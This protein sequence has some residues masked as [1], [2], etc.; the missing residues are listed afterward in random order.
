MTLP[1]TLKQ[2][3][4]LYIKC[5]AMYTN[6]PDG[7]TL[8]TDAQYDQ[9]E[10]LIR[11]E[12]PGWPPLLAVGYKVKKDDIELAPNYM[13][14]L[15]KAY[16]DTLQRFVSKIKPNQVVVA[17]PKY[18]GSSVRIRFKN[19]AP[20]QMVTRGDGE[21]GG[22][23]SF[24]LPFINAP[25][26][27]TNKTIDVRC[28]VY[29]PKS[30]YQEHYKSR[31]DTARA[32]ANGAMNRDL[33]NLDTDLMH[34]LVFMPLGVF[35]IKPTM[36]RTI[37]PD[38]TTMVTMKPSALTTALPKLLTKLLATD[39][40]ADG[41]VIMEDVP[42]VYSSLAYPDFAFAYKENSEGKKVTV[43]KVIWQVAG[44][45]RLTPKVM[46][47]PT[48]MDG[49]SVKHATA[50]NVRQMIDNGIG[51]GAVIEI[52]MGGDI[53]PYIQRVIK[54]AKPQMPEI[55]YEIRGAFAYAVNSDDETAE[56]ISVRALLKYIRGLGLEEVADKGLHDLY[57]AGIQDIHAL[58]A[59]PL[60]KL[61]AVLGQAKGKKLHDQ[62]RKMPK[63]RLS[64]IMA[65]SGA[66]GESFGMTLMQKLELEIDLRLFLKDPR[67]IGKH[68]KGIPDFGPKR[69]QALVERTPALV[70]EAKRWRDGFGIDLS[71]AEAPESP[72]STKLAGRFFSW[73]GY[74]SEEQEQWVIDN[75]GAVISLGKRTTDLFYNPAG[76]FMTKV[77]RA[78]VDGIRVWSKT[79]FPPK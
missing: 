68:L 20:I 26:V 12:D 69:V 76:K 75:G 38:I 39:I 67:N 64:Q 30:V 42:L 55:E 21:V 8:L 29:L 6:D 52:V 22:D 56:R 25:R 2:K 9:L 41:L 5:R 16:P 50:H 3:K 70:A 62:I 78:K 35:G 40:P 72:A 53:I 71:T 4:A 1:K 61:Q 15:D 57:Q 43:R 10:R 74:R 73:T 45:G 34:D 28:E 36:W 17:M 13:V 60:T 33:A 66:L 19:K 44:S 46:F 14:S 79:D 49:A 18:D 7:K 48:D 27:T 77:E 32:A 11:N 65:Y 24:M 58:C 23:I 47:D 59:A 31:F 51:P 37:C 54:R 63:P